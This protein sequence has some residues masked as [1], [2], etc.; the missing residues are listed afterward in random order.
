MTKEQLAADLL[1]NNP[2]FKSLSE[3]QMLLDS[4][5][6]IVKYSEQAVFQAMQS[7][8]ITEAENVSVIEEPAMNWIR[9][10]VK[11]LL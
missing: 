10:A 11:E 8:E 5:T 7:L 9:A 2:L 6:D 1:A 3:T 4:G